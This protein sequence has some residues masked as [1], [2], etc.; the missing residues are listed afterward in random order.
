MGKKR[1]WEEASVTGRVGDVYKCLGKLGGRGR[2]APASGNITV[3]DFNEQFERVS[4]DR[5]EE[6]HRVIDESVR[7]AVDLRN[8]ARAREANEM[9][10][11]V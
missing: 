11:E 1:E 4:K 8:D 7:G 5:Y 3:N 10:N 2:K 6:N 9:L